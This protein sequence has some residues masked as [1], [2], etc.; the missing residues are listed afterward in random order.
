M[1]ELH[2]DLRATA[3]SI[4]ADAERLAAIEEEKSTL[5]DDH[6][7]LL[8]LSLEATRIVRKLVPKTA[9]ELELAEEAGQP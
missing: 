7:R 8:E 1:A 4:A 9:A 3:D 6:P 2:D 5:A